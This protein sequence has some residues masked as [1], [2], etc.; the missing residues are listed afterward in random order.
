MAVFS[1]LKHCL[2]SRL[3]D[4]ELRSRQLV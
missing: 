4:K 3:S 1:F 2:P